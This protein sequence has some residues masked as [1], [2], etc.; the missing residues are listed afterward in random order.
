L[1]SWFAGFSLALFL[2]AA[3]GAGPCEEVDAAYGRRDDASALS[4]DRAFAETG[5]ATAST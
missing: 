4:I 5:D 3:A 2:V 1:N